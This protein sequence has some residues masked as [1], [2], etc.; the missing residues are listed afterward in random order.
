MSM[1]AIAMAL[2][3]IMKQN[4]L[5]RNN[6][7]NYLKHEKTAICKYGLLNKSLLSSAFLK[8]ESVSIDQNLD[9]IGYRLSNGPYLLSILLIQT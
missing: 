1:A 4:R 5:K 6:D 3:I 7:I 2:E 8:E 9:I